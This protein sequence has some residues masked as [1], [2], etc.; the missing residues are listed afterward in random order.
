MEYT[1]KYEELKSI[2]NSAIREIKLTDPGMSIV[3]LE[4]I[5]AS[6]PEG[7]FNTEDLL[8]VENKS[9][10]YP[11][12]IPPDRKSNKVILLLHGLNE[13][14][15]IKYLTWAFYLC[16]NTGSYVILFPISFHINRSPSSWKDPRAMTS[17][18]RDRLQTWNDVQM[19]SFANIAL[20][21]RLTQDP[22]RF[23]ISGYQTASDIVKL[24]SQIKYGEHEI[25]PLG[26]RVN[27]FAYSIGAFLSQILLMGNPDNLFT[28]S[29][30]F[31]FCGGSVF[32]CMKGTSKLI[33][34]SVAFNEIYDFYVD[35]FEEEIRRKQ[36]IYGRITESHLGM[37][38]RSMIDFGRFRSVRENFL[39][40]VRDQ[41]K[42]ISLLKDTVIPPEGIMKTMK[43]P[44]KNQSEVEVWDF[45]FNYSH[46]NP[47][48]LTDKS[49]AGAVDSWFER[50]FSEACLYLA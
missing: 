18:V 45:P 34:D 44:V 32:C 4:F 31:L 50:L 3:N 29:R 20:S 9:F 22:M 14:S 5:S 7:L 26:S 47:F 36:T 27:M 39:G 28:G 35:D 1:K 23:F 38:F 25:I 8:I 19:S 49:K 11:V 41:V 12:F 16:R 43:D 24:M 42:S 15:W 21:R 33:M 6:N 17:S 13:R 2:Y 48:P 37:A 10:T 30:L 40:R 46:E